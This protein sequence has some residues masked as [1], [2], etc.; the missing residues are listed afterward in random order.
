MSF[1]SSEQRKAVMSKYTHSGRGVQN[2]MNEKVMSMY[3][4][5]QD[6][7]AGFDLTDFGSKEN[8]EKVLKEN[9]LDNYKIELKKTIG[10]DSYRIFVWSNKDVKLIT[11]NNPITGE[12]SGGKYRRENEIGYASYIGIEG[13]ELAVKDLFNSI[14]KHA[15]Y[16]KEEEYGDRSFI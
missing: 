11:G 6:Y 4:E 8:F 2:R 13:K 10:A 15:S 3:N 7:K 9:H 5:R 16:I 14:K 1:K 12:Y